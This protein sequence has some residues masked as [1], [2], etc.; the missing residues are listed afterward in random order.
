MLA[1]A[2]ITLI[3]QGILDDQGNP[4]GVMPKVKRETICEPGGK[5]RVV[6]ATNAALVIYGQPFAHVCKELL[7]IDPLVGPG[8]EAGYQ[9]W[10]F[11]K[12]LLSV[13]YEIPEHH[14]LMMGDYETAT[15]FIEHELAFRVCCS[16]FNGARIR[17]SYV[18]S[19]LRLLCSPRE[20]WYKNHL[21]FTTRRGI[22]MGDPGSKIVLTILTRCVFE[23]V[24]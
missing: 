20:V 24:K 18:Y 10:E 7:A 3:E 8:L 1:W 19:Y 17:S 22:L 16:F 12:R 23:S 4:T 9:G 5:V 21:Q 6:T 15:D 11:Y 13:G 2:F 14:Q